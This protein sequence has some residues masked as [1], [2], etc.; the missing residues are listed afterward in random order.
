MADLHPWWAEL[1]AV[2][3]PDSCAVDPVRQL[4]A[5]IA[6]GLAPGITIIE[7]RETEDRALAGL[8]LDIEVE[9]PQD[10]AAPI[11]AVEPIA[12]LFGSET[13]QPAVLALRAEFPHTMHQ[14]CTREGDPLSLCVDDRPWHEA[15]LSFTLAD[16]LRRIQ[17]WLAKAA[18]G[19]LHDPAQPLE[20]LFFHNP[21]SIVVPAAALEER[22]TPPEL[23]G[24]RLEENERMIITRVADADSNAPT[25]FVVVALRAAPQGMGRLRQAPRTLAGLAAQLK[26][27]GIDLAAILQEKITTWS[28]LGAEAIR[29]LNAH[30]ALI[31]AFPITDAGGR[32]SDDLR[33]FVTHATAGDVGEALGLLGQNNS[34]VGSAKAYVKLIGATPAQ[35]L[36]P[37][38]IDPVD[39]HLAFDRNTGAAVSGLPEADKR[40]VVLV[41]AGALGSQLAVN[42]ARE[43][44]FCW[45]LVDNDVLLPH[46]LARHALYPIDIGAP[47][48]LGL[49]RRLDI[50]LGEK[51]IPIAADI[52]APA[53]D[54]KP[55][56]EEQLAQADLIID[57]S[58]SVAVSRHLSGLADVRGRRLSLF[59][60]PAGTAIVLLAES[61]NRDVTLHDLEAQYHRMLQLEDG[62]AA[63]LQPLTPGLRY[64]GS[65]RAV[66]NRIPAGRAALLSAIAAQAVVDA[67]S[68]DES[69]IR[70]WTLDEHNAV[71]LRQQAG[72]AVERQ[73]LGDWTVTYS[74]SVAGEIT[75][76]R[77]AHLPRETGGILLGII[78]TSRRTIHVIQ[79][80][81][82]PPDSSGTV[83]GFERGVTGLAA[84]V[85]QAADRALH[86]IRYVGEWHSHPAGSSTRP[87]VTDIRQICWLTGEL[88][89][90]GLPALM[91]IAGD[92]GSLSVILAGTDIAASDGPS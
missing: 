65:C 13:L 27:C 7:A 34:A 53:P 45:T 61:A 86:Q 92:R 10:L 81:A 40:P 31:I 67:A 42:L 33:A 83:T 28:G 36:P 57:A 9:R 20:P 47:K 66:T 44:R 70:I 30:L 50:L 85:Q 58:A 37:L 72:D 56:L 39:V 3:E 38:P 74:Q 5:H 26:E 35:T 68:S 87:S 79:A 16:F 4:A 48:V 54:V 12:V 88:E 91:L 69:A 6:K 14:N 29:R 11:R 21:S 64:S 77:T 75:A 51:A 46:N 84:K 8:L 18:R 23:L 49:A 90:E 55:Q 71:S 1:G 82:E 43:G 19:E 24:Y 80:L 89:N 62:L 2:V 22:E 25:A 52:L 73:T 41:G 32:A 17:L 59:F 15:Q 78:D 60:N 63:H 76:L